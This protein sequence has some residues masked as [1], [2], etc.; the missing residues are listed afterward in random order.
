MV[1]LQLLGQDSAGHLQDNVMNHRDK[2]GSLA[3]VNNFIK[4]TFAILQ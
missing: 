3:S 2:K 4:K 1:S